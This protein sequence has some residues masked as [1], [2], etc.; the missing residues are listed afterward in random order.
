M[1]VYISGPITG[2]ADYMARFEKIENELLSQGFRVVNPAKENAKF[3]EGTT[4]ETYMKESVKMLADCD[5]I[6]LMRGWQNSNGAFLEWKLAVDLKMTI[7][8]EP[9]AVRK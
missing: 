5:A 4:W 1:R 8:F 6:Y 7:I 3:P 2:T 9:G